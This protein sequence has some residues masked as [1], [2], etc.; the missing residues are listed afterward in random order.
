MA[1]GGLASGH[2]GHHPVGGEM[3]LQAPAC[4]AAFALHVR[5]E[6]A[7]EQASGVHPIDQQLRVISEIGKAVAQ[8]ALARPL[9]I[10][11]IG[12][13]A[14]VAVL[15]DGNGAVF[16]VIGDAAGKFRACAIA[17]IEERIAI[18]VITDGC[19]A[20]SSWLYQYKMGFFRSLIISV[21]AKT[22]F[23]SLILGL[24][25]VV[26]LL[27]LQLYFWIFLKQTIAISGFHHSCGHWRGRL[28]L[29]VSLL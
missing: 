8:I 10:G 20:D 17:I 28:I 15:G 29:S 25:Q 23:L 11:G 7:G 26:L 14:G 21:S 22:Q 24:T 1:R 18:G 2:I 4:D 6:I 19:S 3:V 16:T 5:V 13:G 9:A 27:A 12:E